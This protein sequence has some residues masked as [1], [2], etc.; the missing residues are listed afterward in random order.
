MF[1]F[2]VNGFNQSFGKRAKYLTEDDYNSIRD[3][4]KNVVIT[5]SDFDTIDILSKSFVFIDPP[6]A[7]TNNDYYS[8]FWNDKKLLTLMDFIREIDRN[9]GYF[10]YTD[11]LNPLHDDFEYE[12]IPLVRGKFTNISPSAKTRETSHQEVYFTNIKFGL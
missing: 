3:K 9:G 10:L 1:R 5:N 7:S 8:K 12:A 2:S 4:V 11:V 6:Y